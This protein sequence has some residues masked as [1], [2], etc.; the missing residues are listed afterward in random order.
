MTWPRFLATVL[1]VA[2]VLW[3]LALSWRLHPARLPF[4]AALPAPADARA[5]GPAD[6]HTVASPHA[7]ADAHAAADFRAGAAVG[8]RAAP[9]PADS[10]ADADARTPAKPHAHRARVRRRPEHAAPR[11]WRPSAAPP[12][13]GPGGNAPGQGEPADL[14]PPAGRRRPHHAAPQR[15]A[16]R[17][18]LRRRATEARLERA[19]IVEAIPDVVDLFTVAVAAGLNVRLAVA[20]VASRAPPGPVAEALREVEA[21]VGRGGARLADVLD[22]LPESLGEAIRP[23]SRALVDAE[24]YGSPLRAG[25]ERLAD[26]ARRARQQ[27]AEEAA[28]RIPVQ[29]LLPLVACILPAFGLLTVAPLIAGGLRALRL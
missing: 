5:P 18:R 24:R 3:V 21:E 12:P 20:A 2:W 28:R 11:W 8:T 14:R 22:R 13:S 19:R 9:N 23:L 7:A 15:R 25:L 1:P 4:P 17:P 10:H 27:R 16:R 29:L 6:P 26:D